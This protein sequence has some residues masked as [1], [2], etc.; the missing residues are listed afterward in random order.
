MLKNELKRAF[1][2]KGMLLAIL[3]GQGINLYYIYSLLVQFREKEK[4]IA[5]IGEKVG[6]EL[7]M[8][9]SRNTPFDIWI[10]GHMCQAL[11]LFM[12]FLPIIA[13]L[14]YAASYASEKKN[15]YV[16]NVIYREGRGRYKINKMIASFISG[17]TAVVSVLIVNL[18]WCFTCMPM[19][20]PVACSNA[21]LADARTMLGVMY[22][23]HPFLYCGL[24]IVMAFI[25]AGTISLVSILI[26]EL[27]TN[28]FT[29][30][31]FPF[32]VLMVL[33]TLLIEDKGYYLPMQFLRAS[34]SG[35]KLYLVPLIA[36]II[37]PISVLLFVV[38]GK[39]NDIL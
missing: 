38:C 20:M 17:G 12:Y 29:V 30:T 27:T 16:K 11:V 33:N 28:I 34:N 35:Y 9:I 25:F 6:I 39:K 32:L 36:V 13:T 7:Y 8:Q 5:Q 24:Y 18:M 19:K 26:S 31:L 23:D 37:I 4:N 2:N 10:I 21:P 14:P 22:Y 3:L 1:T 15:G